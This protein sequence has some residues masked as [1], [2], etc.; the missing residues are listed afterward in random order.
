MINLKGE[1]EI[2]GKKDGKTV[3]YDKGSNLVTYWAR[4]AIMHLLTGDTFAK[5][6]KKRSTSTTDGTLLSNQTYFHDNIDPL[7]DENFYWNK[8]TF[9]S[10]ESERQYPFMPVKMLLGTGVEV[11]TWGEIPGLGIDNEWSEVGESSFNTQVGSSTNSDYSNSLTDS[12]TLPTK[13]RTANSSVA[14]IKEAPIITQDDC[15]ISGAIKNGGYVSIS[16]KDGK[17]TL[18]EGYGRILKPEFRGIGKPCFIY[19]LRGS[20]TFEADNSQVML[21]V[22]EVGDTEIESKIT[23]TVVLPEQTGTNSDDFY[24]YNGY[25][26]KEVGLFSDAFLFNKNSKENYDKRMPYGLMFAKR[27]IAPFTKTADSSFTIRWTIYI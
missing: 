24:P 19:P 18:K 14:G 27:Y 7:Y 8:S 21:T 11:K 9:E 13:A 12:E 26:I 3:Y 2:I 10:G 25:I 17:T 23:F 15:A 5:D 16:E 1:V 6:G 22:E 20:G 4:H